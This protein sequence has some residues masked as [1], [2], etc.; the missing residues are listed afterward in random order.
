MA[1]TRAR[2]YA[3]PTTKNFFLR[4]A[5]L[6]PSLTAVDWWLERQALYGCLL[7]VAMAV[8]G[9][10]MAVY[11]NRQQGALRPDVTSA[12]GAEPAQSPAATASER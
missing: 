1:K 7:G 9:W 6:V 5:L 3:K 10:R 11:N 4:L 8:L 12:I 2:R